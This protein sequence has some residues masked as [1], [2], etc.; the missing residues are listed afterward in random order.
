MRRGWRVA[1]CT[2]L[3]GVATLSAPG[4]GAAQDLAD[5]D[6]ENLSFRGIGVEWGYLAAPSRVETDPTFGM[7]FDLGYLGPGVRITPSITWWESRMKR[8]EVQELETRV[9]QLANRSRPPGSQP[10]DVDLGQVTWSDLVLGVDAHVVWSVPYGVLTYAGVGVAAHLQ[11]GSGAAIDGTFVEDLLDSVAAGVN[12]HS[13]L[14]YPVNERLRVYGAARYELMG[15]L[16]YLE[17]RFG[18]QV[19][20]GPSAPGEIRR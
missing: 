4:A 1:V 8:G 13:G 2:A 9:N 17:L 3:A 5:F 20:F 14:E 6:Y 10:V 11:D 12:V 19:M 15:D 18:T 16:R 7:R